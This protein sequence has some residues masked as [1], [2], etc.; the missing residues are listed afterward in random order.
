VGRWNGPELILV[1]KVSIFDLTYGYLKMFHQNEDIS[2]KFKVATVVQLAQLLDRGW[3]S[4]ELGAELRRHYKATE[5]KKGLDLPTHF[6]GRSPQR[7]NLLRTGKFYYHNELR[8][9]TPP[10]V[11]DFDYNTGEIKRV[12]QDYYLEM[13][14]SYTLEDL[15]NYFLSKQGLCHKEAVTF[16]RVK[17]AIKWLL[18]QFEVD[19]VLFMIDISNDIIM[20]NNYNKLRVPSDVKEYYADAIQL[21]QKKVT[22][23]RVSGGDQIV[24]RRRLLSH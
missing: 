3:T 20:T 11:V 6:R 22:E 23:N 5:G 18:D 15:T 19:L 10:P 24:P 2:Q 13:R 9:T 14:A 21:F 17:G 7:T 4:E 16:G 1:R 8:V 12:V